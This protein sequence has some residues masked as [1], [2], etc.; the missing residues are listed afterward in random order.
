MSETPAEELYLRG[1]RPASKTWSGLVRW[2][3]VSLPAEDDVRYIRAD[4]H[5]AQAAEIAA[6]KADLLDA[7][8]AHLWIRKNRELAAEVERLKRNDDSYRDIANQS[9]LNINRLS[10]LADAQAAEIAALREQLA[11]SCDDERADPEGLA[12]PI[13]ANLNLAERRITAQAAEI[14]RITDVW[15]ALHKENIRLAGI[16]AALEDALKRLVVRLCG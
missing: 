16:N 6:L 12:C 4:L 13:G 5:D 15:H 3:P 8:D 11:R 14:E 1:Y 7:S 10:V 2:L 9:R